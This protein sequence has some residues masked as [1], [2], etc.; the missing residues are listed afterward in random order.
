MR[1]YEMPME[2]QIKLLV[3][4]VSSLGEKI[5]AVDK[6]IDGVDKKVDAIDKKFE[7]RFDAVDKKFDGIDKKF[8]GIDKKFDGIDQKFDGI[9]LKLDKLAVRL[10]ETHAIAKL[11]LEGIQ[12]V[13]ESI[14]EKF[15]EA[16][17]KSAA[18]T[19]LLKSLFV[20]VRKRVEVIEQR[21][22]RRRRS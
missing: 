18:Q 10:D 17:K 8:D 6:K 5:D 11:G 4:T 12:G 19:E 14:D 16:A 1:E 2:E 9:D 15:E 22:P 13:R 20:H 7:G 21:K 3:K